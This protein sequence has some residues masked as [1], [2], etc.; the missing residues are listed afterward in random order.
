VRGS[1]TTIM[2][3]AE[4]I[5]ILKS[6]QSRL[7]AIEAKVGTGGGGASAGAA[8]GGDGE[9]GSAA[10]EAYQEL[11]DEHISAFK[12]ACEAIGGDT[13]PLGNLVEQAALATKALI[14]TASESKAPDASAMQGVLG[15]LSG[16]IQEIVAYR[17]A[18]RATKEKNTLWAIAESAG[19][20]GWVAVPKT[21]GPYVKEMVGSAQFYTNKI[22]R[23]FKGKDENQ[24]AFANSYVDFHNA[25]IGYIKQ[26]HTT[27]LTWNPNGGVAKAPATPA[28]PAAAPAPKKAPAAAKPAAKAGGA[29]LFAELN[30]GDGITSAL[31][32]V[33]R[34]Q[35][36]KDKKI[37]GVVKAK[38]AP[39]KKA[40]APKQPPVCE[41][42]GNKWAIDFQ[43]HPE[44][45][46]TI[47]VEKR[48]AV[49]IY[50]CDG[51]V[52]II[53]GICNS[54]LIDNCKKTG[55]V[56]DG[57]VSTCEI[58]NSQSIKVQALQA[59]PT[60]SIDKTA[61]AQVILSKDSMDTEIVTGTSSELNV[62][63]P[64]ATDDADPIE[65]PI[66]EQFKTVVKEGKLVTEQ[67]DH[68]GG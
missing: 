62:I 3:N 46:I 55:V 6:I 50:K 35:T 19:A 8:A 1:S 33:D 26:Y 23:E 44:Q 11:I 21:P 49:N 5:D 57:A 61:G 4:V 15:P 22:L 18:H 34:S 36:N 25:V 54:I 39:V 13:A 7:S 48:Q 24:V 64:G 28:A 59:V 2:S 40:A 20:F 66:P 17:D 52:I 42:R 27:G 10:A 53:K 16:K 56:F 38:A 41:L 43:F 14:Q 30:K 31:K 47:E 29:G 68:S 63:F 67:V 9:G 60:V 32:K 12:A 51:A 45:P 37:S 58:V 65:L